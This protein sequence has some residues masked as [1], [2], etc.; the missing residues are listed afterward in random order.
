MLTSCPAVL[1][2]NA[3]LAIYPETPLSSLR[4]TYTSVLNTN[5]TSPILVTESFLPLLKSTSAD[6]RVIQVS[7]TRGSLSAT[8][9]EK[10]PP[11]VAVSYPASKA[12]LNLATLLLAQ[13]EGNRG[14]VVFQCSSPGHCRTDF[15]GNSGKKEPIEGA[16]VAVEL[17]LEDKE[18]ARARECGI[19]EIEGG[20]EMERAEW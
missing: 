12:A 4:T 1:I 2:N 16:R 13:R 9:N 6:P 20:R 5:V 17:V 14:V 10:L 18:G 19:W 7:S 3:A 8:A 11:P 15:N